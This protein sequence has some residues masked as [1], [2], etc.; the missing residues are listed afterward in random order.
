M[1]ELALLGDLSVQSIAHR[2]C[3]RS[4]P[5]L[6]HWKAMGKPRLHSSQSESSRR[7]PFAVA[8]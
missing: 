3:Y 5:A 7:Q 8:L 4:R 2:G 6:R 1:L